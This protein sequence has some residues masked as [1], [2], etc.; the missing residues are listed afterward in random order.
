MFNLGKLTKEINPRYCGEGEKEKA[1]V[2]AR[3]TLPGFNLT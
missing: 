1:G 2:K 3:Q